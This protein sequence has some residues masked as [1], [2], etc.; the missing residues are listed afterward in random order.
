MSIDR[1]RVPRWRQGFRLQYEAAQAAHVLL[2]PEGMVRFNMSAGAIGALVDGT[3]TVAAIV[4]QLEQ[5]FPG[6]PELGDD[7][8]GFMET[9]RA[10]HWIEF[11]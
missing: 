2:Y 11:V 3:R 6:V 7:V 4:A 5:Q 8:E 9:A 1:E 10:E